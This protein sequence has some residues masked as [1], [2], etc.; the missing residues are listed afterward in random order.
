MSRQMDDALH[1]RIVALCQQADELVDND[2]ADAGLAKYGEAW[3]LLP[4][5][6]LDWE[7]ATWILAAIGDVHYL[8]G[9][10]DLALAAFVDALLSRRLR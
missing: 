8:A 6:K 7:A 10:F 1:S 2:E 5:P 4:E 9:R 3:K